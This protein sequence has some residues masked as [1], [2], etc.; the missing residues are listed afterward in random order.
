MGEQGQ[1]G[2][3]D[4][5]NLGRNTVPVERTLNRQGRSL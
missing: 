3:D 4:Q 1:G 5:P 2:G